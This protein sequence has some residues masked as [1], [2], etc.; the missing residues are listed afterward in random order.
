MAMKW[1]KNVPKWSQSDPR[2]IPEVPDIFQNIFNF[3]HFWGPPTPP[4]SQKVD[5]NKKVSR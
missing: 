4:P 3:F 5:K 2:Q 1:L